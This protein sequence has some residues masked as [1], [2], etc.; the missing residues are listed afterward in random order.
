MS[1]K[2]TKG[3]NLSLTAKLII[4]ELDARNISYNVLNSGDKYLLLRYKDSKNNQRL[5][6]GVITD[7]T[8]AVGTR[9][10]DNK[11]DTYMVAKDLGI[12]TPETFIFDESQGFEVSNKY[13]VVKPIDSAHGNGITTAINSNA[14]LKQAVARAH[15][16]SNNI[17]VQQYIPSKYEARLLYIDSDFVAGIQRVPAT[18]TGDGR[19]TIEQLIDIEN[20]NGK[21]KPNYTG[22]L[23]TIPKDVALAYLNQRALEIPPD[24]QAVQVVGTANIGTGGYG[25]NIT[26]ELPK[27]LIEQGKKLVEY[28]GLDVCALDFI[29]DSGANFYLLEINASPSL[30]IHHTVQVGDPIDVTTLFVDMILLPK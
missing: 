4:D 23:C 13:W 16:F 2:Q 11:F 27:E 3:K 1:N 12:R 9:I 14:A 25:K 30:F 15:Q 21:R 29:R 6:R 17:L 5:L 26:N 24:G 10:A 20:S 19:H 22:E 8:S 28:T 7:A 18:V